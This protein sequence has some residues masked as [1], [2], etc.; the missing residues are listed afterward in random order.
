MKEGRKGAIDLATRNND[1][2][3]ALSSP[4]EGGEGQGGTRND[5]KLL[6]LLLRLYQCGKTARNSSLSSKRTFNLT[7]RPNGVRLVSLLII[8]MSRMMMIVVLVVANKYKSWLFDWVAL[9]VV[10]QYGFIIESF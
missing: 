7:N 1:L 5:D 6:L 2:V 9:T 4:R 10:N 3:T 8:V